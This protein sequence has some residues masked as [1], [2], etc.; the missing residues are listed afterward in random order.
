M[1]KVAETDMHL[2]G[3]QCNVEVRIRTTSKVEAPFL[4]RLLLNVVVEAGSFVYE[5]AVI[6]LPEEPKQ[7][8]D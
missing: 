7:H 8:A 1:V 2:V 3:C 5:S 4:G 6:L